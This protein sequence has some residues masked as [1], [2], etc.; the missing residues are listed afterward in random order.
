MAVLPSCPEINVEV[1]VNGEALKEYEDDEESTTRTKVT[2]YVE[3]AS[4][5]NF[6]IRYA[7]APRHSSRHGVRVRI[8]IDGR[9]MCGTIHRRKNFHGTHSLN[10]AS[11]R[12]A[13]GKH[14]MSKFRFTELDIGKHKISTTPSTVLTKC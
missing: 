13:S 4:E 3:A 5:T 1:V 11:S 10:G 9:H 8:G 12:L 14:G 7:I 2:K 6:E